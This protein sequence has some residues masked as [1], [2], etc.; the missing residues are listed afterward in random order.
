MSLPKKI[1]FSF[2][3]VV[4][5]GSYGF[6]SFYDPGST[7][8]I[9]IPIELNEVEKPQSY[10]NSE[11]IAKLEKQE[12]IKKRQEAEEKQFVKATDNKMLDFDALFKA[13]EGENTQSEQKFVEDKKP[14]KEVVVFRE[15]KKTPVTKPR[16][17]GTVVKAQPVQEI[18]PALGDPFGDSFGSSNE[19][20]NDPSIVIESNSKPSAKKETVIYVKAS[21]MDG[22]KAVK[23]G[24]RVE[25]RI[26]EPFELD[27]LKIQKNEIFDAFV[28]SIG[29]R[30][31]F[32]VS[33][34]GGL[35]GSYEI[36]DTDYEVGMYV[37]PE[38]IE[39]TIYQEVSEHAEDELIDHTG[40]IAVD[41]TKSVVESA[42]KNIRKQRRQT[43]ELRV[44]HPVLVAIKS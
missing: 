20:L 17:V 19:P 2:L 3:V 29:E 33:V 26:L 9:E 8:R 32:K 13:P 16:T 23:K 14:E 21:L 24:T 1:A 43:I 30:V 28:T 34:I 12:E 31:K 11:L 27:G 42:R 5:T 36:H 37:G 15:T 39:G 10:T 25:F 6:L 41:L 35:K 38:A 44:Q 4:F 40:V 18:R 7:E 22:N